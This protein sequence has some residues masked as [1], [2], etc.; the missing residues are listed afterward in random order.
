MKDKKIIVLLNGETVQALAIGKWLK[1]EGYTVWSICDDKITY[2]YQSPYADMKF[3]APSIHDNP[4]DFH[5]YFIKFLNGNRIDGVIPM[6]DYSASYLASHK[7]E[8]STLTQFIIPDWEVFISAY[9]K[10]RLMKICRDNEFPHPLTCDLSE[11]ELD[12]ASS[13]MRYPALIKPNITTGGRGFALVH[14]SEELHEKYPDI[15][16]EYGDC[17]LQEFIPPGGRQFKVSLFFN[18]EKELLNSTV[19]HKARFYPENGGSSCC[20]I[21]VDRPDLVDTC[22]K[23]L[24]TIGWV[25]FADFDLIEDPRDGVVKIMEINPRVP[26][27]VKL[28]LVSGINFAANIADMTVGIQP[29]VYEYIS[30]KCLRYFALDMLW[31][32]YSPNRFKTTPNWFKLFGKNVFLQ[33][34]G[35]LRPFIIGNLSG[36]IKQL[37]PKF[38]KAKA[39][40]R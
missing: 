18:N 9:D 16:T 6:N 27:C 12:S 17:H 40:L 8:L 5:A 33:D 32:L 23:V 28:S 4:E 7:D 37:N 21:S 1:K 10:N 31:L 30:G 24:H 2:G 20:S 34:W 14:N 13:Y 39:G 19:F 22:A 35:G 15:R 29:K 26:A 25:G 3:I 11:T 36:L 38:R